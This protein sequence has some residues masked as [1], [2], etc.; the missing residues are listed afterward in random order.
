MDLVITLNLA[1]QFWNPTYT[2]EGKILY[3]DQVEIYS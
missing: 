3:V 1:E 2:F